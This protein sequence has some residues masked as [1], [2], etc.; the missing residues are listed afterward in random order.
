MNRPHSCNKAALKSALLGL[1]LA[2]GCN[3][4]PSVDV[5]HQRAAAPSALERALLYI[6]EADSPDESSRA[7]VVAIAHATPRV[8]PYELSAGT[9]TWYV[10]PGSEGREVV[11]LTSGRDA[12]LKGGEPLSSVKSFVHVFDRGGEVFR[13]EL[14]GRF[15]ALT[16]SDDGRFAVAYS[17]SGLALTDAVAVLDLQAKQGSASVLHF[18][19]AAPSSFAF[20]P[21]AGGQPR[22]MLVR[23]TNTLHVV[24][25][26]HLERKVKSV[27]LT[28]PGDG[29]TL[30]VGQVLFDQ[31]Q[32]YIQEQGSTDVLVLA[33]IPSDD[34]EGAFD[35]APL[36]LATDSSVSAISLVDMNQRTEVVALGE[37]ALTLLDPVTGNGVKT[38][39]PNAFDQIIQFSGTSPLDDQ[40]R[41]RA[42]LLETGGTRIGFA[43]FDDGTAWEQQTVETVGLTNQ[44]KGVIPVLDRKLV[45]LLYRSQGLG[46]VDLQQRTVSPINTDTPVASTLLD[47]PADG[48]PRLWFVL[49]DGRVGWVDL[50]RFEVNEVLLNAA[51]SNVLSIAGDKHQIAVVHDSGAGYVTLLDPEKPA[52]ETARELVSFLYSKLFD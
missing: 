23:G 9:A 3:D 34:G 37:S 18:N 32:I 22:L 8:T 51:A 41:T 45:V 17:P 26:E 12:S 27:Q 15:Q 25:L 44:V 33:R 42:L 49:D 11:V 14:P 29:R 4:E 28:A 46:I 48:R 38:Q 43:D 16:L 1:A 6:D 52:R 7:L 35:L 50:D 21:A 24:Q 19:E 36:Q 20:S 10:R 30:Q 39:V 2:W 47:Q 13:K 5:P 40:E 31:D